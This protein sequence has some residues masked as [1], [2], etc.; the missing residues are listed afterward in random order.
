MKLQIVRAFS[1]PA[2]LHA[3]FHHPP[4][5]LRAVGHCGAGALPHNHQR[6]LPGRGRDHY[7]VRRHAQGAP[8]GWGVAGIHAGPLGLLEDPPLP[9]FIAGVL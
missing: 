5:V 9:V 6:I 4:R 8:V 7:G 3:F 1:A 2:S